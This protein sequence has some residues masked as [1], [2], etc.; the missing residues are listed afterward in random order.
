M[1]VFN[2]NSLKGSDSLS[3]WFAA[4]LL[5]EPVHCSENNGF[6]YVE[7]LVEPMVMESYCELSGILYNLILCTS[8]PFFCNHLGE[9]IVF[10][11]REIFFA[12]F[13]RFRKIFFK[14]ASRFRWDSIPNFWSPKVQIIDSITVLIFNMPWKT[15]FHI[16]KYKKFEVT[17]SAELLFL[18][19]SLISSRVVPS[20][21]RFQCFWCESKSGSYST[22]LQ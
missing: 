3:T 20:S 5:I 4:Y 17:P 6:R 18:S 22:S 1:T 10:L 8:I 14:L 11:C 19:L 15:V 21:L 2:R 16:P 13:E 9:I 7:S 12:R